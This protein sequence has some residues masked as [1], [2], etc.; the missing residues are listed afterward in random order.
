LFCFVC[1]C[2]ARDRTMALVHARQVLCLYALPQSIYSFI[3]WI[4]YS[5]VF[6]QRKL[7]LSFPFLR[8][9]Y[10]EGAVFVPCGFHNK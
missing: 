8:A 2:G 7:R 10:S 9:F 6:S 3:F 5:L 1:I 4:R